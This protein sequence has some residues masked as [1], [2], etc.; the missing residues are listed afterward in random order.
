MVK[1]IF[2]EEE[3]EYEG[4][5]GVG[6]NS[7][8]ESQR[9]EAT[10]K[11]TIAQN[12]KHCWNKFTRF[13][14]KFSELV[15]IITLIGLGFWNIIGQFF[16]TSKTNVDG[17]KPV[18]QPKVGFN[19][20]TTALALMYFFFAFLIFFSMRNNITVLT[21]FGF[22]RGKFTKGMFFIFCAALTLPNVYC[23][24]GDWI[25]WPV[26]IVLAITSVL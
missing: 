21:Y 24:Y 20:L 15:F 8:T 17:K 1:F 25:A 9:L 2:K 12:S 10:D 5:E 7:L 19:L 16:K 14:D 26:F 4:G 23:V 18:S 6:R 3:F 22:M 13:L 11:E